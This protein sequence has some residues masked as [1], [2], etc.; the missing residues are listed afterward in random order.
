MKS[1]KDQQARIIDD[2]THKIV[3]ARCTASSEACIDINDHYKASFNL[4]AFYQGK[5]IRGLKVF[6][7]KGLNA[8][9]FVKGQYYII[10]SSE[11]FM[12]FDG[13]L[14][15]MRADSAECLED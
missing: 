8:K 15:Y 11:G 1:I 12:A 4:N 5:A 3:I 6:H 10:R 7:T 14:G 13:D 2:I 9:R